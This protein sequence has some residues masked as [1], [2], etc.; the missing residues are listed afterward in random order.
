M[1]ICI[2][3]FSH[4]LGVSCIF[5]PVHV[6]ICCGLWP[7]GNTTCLFLSWYQ[8]TRFSSSPRRRRRRPPRPSA[9]ASGRRRRL[10]LAAGE[11]R[12]PPLFLEV[13]S[14]RPRP[15]GCSI[16]ARGSR[17]SRTRPAPATSAA[18]SSGPRPA[19]ASSSGPRPAPVFDP[20]GLPSV[21]DPRG[22]PSTRSP[23]AARCPW[24]SAP[25]P[26]LSW[27][28]HTGFRPA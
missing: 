5:S 15:G 17:P 24:E 1:Y 20:R 22:P 26:R 4:L 21:F 11:L 10:F 28:P 2:C 12:P 13:S 6:T 8:S 3:V 9:A 19:P 25:L 7:P 27:R 16:V 23:S 14:C 18:S